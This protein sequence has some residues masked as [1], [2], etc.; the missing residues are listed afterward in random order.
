MTN[1]VDRLKSSNVNIFT[2][3]ISFLIPI[4]GIFISI[5]NWKRDVGVAKIY[6]LATIIGFIMNFIMLG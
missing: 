3:F 6:A 2:V 1:F 4:F 5:R